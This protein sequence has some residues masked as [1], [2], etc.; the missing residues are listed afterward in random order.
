MGSQASNQHESQ[1]KGCK[2]LN[3]PTMVPLK[4]ETCITWE[5]S[6]LDLVD[7]TT[8][9]NLRQFIMNIPDPERPAEQL[10]HAVNKMLQHDGYIF[11]FNPNQSQSAQEIMAGLLVYLQGMWTPMVEPLK[12]N[13]FFIGPAIEQVADAWWDTQERCIVTK[14]DVEFEDLINQDSNLMFPEDAITM[15]MTQI[16]MEE[17]V[18]MSTGSISTFHTTA[19]PQA[20]VGV[21]PLNKQGSTQAPKETSA[22]QASVLTGT[23]MSEVDFMALM[24][25]VTEALQINSSQ[26]K[27]PPSGSE[28]GTSS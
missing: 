1:G 8:R 5:L 7:S 6:T 28:T 11:H 12:F 16:A 20:K 27:I 26:P 25:Q 3:Q 19:T 9:T 22:D 14:T 2:P 21:R 4:Y 17:E 15:D 10:F 18:G 23:S 24:Q 13:K